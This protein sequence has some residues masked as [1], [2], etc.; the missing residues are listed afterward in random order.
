MR[1]GEAAP[2]TKGTKIKDKIK[3]KERINILI[4]TNCKKNQ[5]KNRQ[6]NKIL[7]KYNYD[8]TERSFGSDLFS[9]LRSIHIFRHMKLCVILYLKIPIKIR[10]L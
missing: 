4:E 8:D 3:H 5:V 9:A 6:I 10:C 1:G 7:S 2:R